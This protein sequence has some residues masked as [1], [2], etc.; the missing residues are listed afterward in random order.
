M[1]PSG[2]EPVIFRFVAQRLNT[3]PRRVTLTNTGRQI[4]LPTD[5][6]MRGVMRYEGSYGRVSYDIMKSKT[7]LEPPV[8]L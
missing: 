5:G 1:T 8:V 7:P 3:V 6:V 2:I 4:S